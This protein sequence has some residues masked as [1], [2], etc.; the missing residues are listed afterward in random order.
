MVVRLPVALQCQRTV[1]PRKTGAANKHERRLFHG[2]AS[3]LPVYLKRARIRI[4][5]CSKNGKRW[6]NASQ[7]NEKEKNKN[8]A[9]CSLAHLLLPY[10]VCFASLV[11]A[12]WEN[13]SFAHEKKPIKGQSIRTRTQPEHLPR[14]QSPRQPSRDL[15]G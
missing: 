9:Q 10:C 13:V 7:K 6:G 2:T 8:K 15:S 14:S 11:S 1:S 4:R 12:L 3:G 5:F